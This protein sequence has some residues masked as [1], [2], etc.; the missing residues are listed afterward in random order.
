MRVRIPTMSP[1]E[2]KY[3]RLVGAINDGDSFAGQRG[4]GV[5]LQQGPVGPL[6][7]A[8][9]LHRA[10]RERRG[11]GARR[12][13]HCEGEACHFSKDPSGRYVVLYTFTAR[14]E[15]DVDVERGEFVTGEGAPCGLVA[16]DADDDE[17]R[18]VVAH[19]GEACPFSK[20]PSGRYVVLYTFTARDENDVDVERGEFVTGEGAPCGLVARDDDDD[21]DRAVVAQSGQ[22]LLLTP[23]MQLSSATSTTNPRP[24]LPPPR[25]ESVDAPYA[26]VTQSAIEAQSAA[27]YNTRSSTPRTGTSAHQP[28]EERVENRRG[29][30]HLISRTTVPARCDRFNSLTPVQRRELVAQQGLCCNCLRAHSVSRC[31]SKCRCLVCGGHHHTKLHLPPSS[32]SSSCSL[33]SS[34]STAPKDGRPADSSPGS[35]VCHGSIQNTMLL[36]TAMVG[37][38]DHNGHIHQ[39]RALIDSGS[40]VS[41]ITEKLAQQLRLPRTSSRL[42]HGL[43]GKQRSNGSVEC[44]IASP[45]GASQPALVAT[46]V[47]LKHITGDLPSAPL[48][49]SV[50]ER[51][52][53]ITLADDRLSVPGPID[54]LIGVDLY[55]R[56]LDGTSYQLGEGLP[57]AHRSIFGWI[58]MGQAPIDRDK[59]ALPNKSIQ[60]SV[61]GPHPQRS[62]RRPARRRPTQRMHNQPAPYAACNCIHAC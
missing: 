28:G 34:S 10:R 27:Y 37:V 19:E 12:V 44:R 62:R 20:D 40:Q 36:G 60:V 14:D 48:C 11:R 9:H 35:T 45:Q 16:G 46:A 42:L 17:D 52:K 57:T 56:I 22:C 47:V 23:E 33:A 7:R 61:G 1:S 49:P 4:L 55:S 53:S 6:R 29:Q 3:Y 32:S 31:T 51:C 41:V 25:F 58:L 30:T 54:F 21:D 2:C 18:A 5:S 59:V 43:G 50:L 8:L 39:V 13:C 15:N 38:Y 26:P 24:L